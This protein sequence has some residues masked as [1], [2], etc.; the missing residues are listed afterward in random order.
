MTDSPIILEKKPLKNSNKMLAIITLNSPKSLNALSLQMIEILQPFIDDCAQDEKV[1]AI[2]LQ[3]AGERAFCAGGDVVQICQRVRQ[4]GIDDS[5]AFDF[6]SQEY[7]LDYA[8]HSLKKPLI[9]WANGYVMGGGIGLMVGGSHRIVT[10]SSRLAMP[11]IN[12]GLYPDVGGSYFLSRMP[13]RLGLWLGLTAA[14]LQAA[15]AVWLGMADICLQE[16]ARDKVLAELLAMSW[17][18]SS[19]EHHQQISD[20]LS[21]WQVEESASRLEQHAHVIA[22]LLQGDSIA[23]IYESLMQPSEYDYL[24]KPQQNLQKG[25]PT[26]AV[27]IYQ[28]WLNGQKQSLAETFLQELVLSV[29]CARHPDFIEGVR[30]LLVDKDNQPKWQ[31]STLKDVTQAWIAEHYNAPTHLAAWQGANPLQQWLRV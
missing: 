4:N 28:Q 9:V 7:R 26:S 16:D 1:L 15:D 11:E 12:I 21:A 29:Q 6:F 30:S 2:F 5:Y 27:L 17:S 24:K 19:A 10:P 20:L 3:G 31:P 23:D 18:A 13:Q 8:L 22:P 25:S 14:Q